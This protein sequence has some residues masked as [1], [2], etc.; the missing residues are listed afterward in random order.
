MHKKAIKYTVF[1]KQ[2]LNL[3]CVPFIWR[4]SPQLVVIDPCIRNQSTLESQIT[5][6]K[7]SVLGD[8]KIDYFLEFDGD[9]LWGGTVL[10]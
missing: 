2:V 6:L 3:H 8:R 4:A 7:L 1:N 9:A 10:N 5:L